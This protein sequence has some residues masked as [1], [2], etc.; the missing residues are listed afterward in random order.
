[1]KCECVCVCV[2]V[3]V[4]MYVCIE[5]GTTQSSTSEAAYDTQGNIE[6]FS[7]YQVVYEYNPLLNFLLIDF[8]YFFKF[9]S[10]QLLQ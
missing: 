7:Q 6:C 2:C 5:N 10:A 4:C 9:C 3:C 8:A 1:M